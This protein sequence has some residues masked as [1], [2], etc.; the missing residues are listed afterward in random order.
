MYLMNR[1]DDMTYAEIADSLNVGV[2]AIEKQMSK[3]L[4]ILR[5]E[6]GV[7]I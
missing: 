5:K 6:L 1:I 2:K 7:K 3:A 4:A